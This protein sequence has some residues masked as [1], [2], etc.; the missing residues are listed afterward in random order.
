MSFPRCDGLDAIDFGHQDREIGCDLAQV[1][2]RDHAKAQGLHILREETL[3]GMGMRSPM[4]TGSVLP[5][6]AT[7]AVPTQAVTRALPHAIAHVAAGREGNL[8]VRADTANGTGVC[9]GVL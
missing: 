7:L 2:F 5:H 3:Q 4:L 1:D 6:H 8:T 9:I